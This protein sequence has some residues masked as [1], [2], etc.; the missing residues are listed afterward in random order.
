[1]RGN[2][3]FQLSYNEDIFTKVYPLKTQ[4]ERKYLLLNKVLHDIGI[5]SELYT[6]EASELTQ[7][8]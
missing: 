1:M 7:G 4:R 6:D 5:P 8:N 3:H 2:G